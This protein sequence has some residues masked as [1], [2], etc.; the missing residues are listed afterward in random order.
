VGV[1]GNSLDEELEDFL[2]AGADLVIVKPL[3]NQTLQLLL[4]FISTNGFQ[5]MPGYRIEIV[6]KEYAWIPRVL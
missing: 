3:K 4:K 1:T 2:V 5:T 6:E